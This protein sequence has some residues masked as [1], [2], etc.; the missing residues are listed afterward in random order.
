MKKIARSPGRVIGIHKHVIGPQT[1]KFID[2]LTFYVVLIDEDRRLLMANRAVE[3][4]YDLKSSEEGEDPD[5]IV[6]R[7]AD[8]LYPGCCLDE[9]VKTGKNA[10]RDFFD[11]ITQAWIRSETFAS[12]LITPDGKEVYINLAREITDLK[13]VEAAVEQTSQELASSLARVRDLNTKIIEMMGRIME[14]KDPYTAGH[15]RRVAS[16]AT[17]LAD[18]L[19]LSPDKKEGISLASSIHDIGKIYLPIEILSKP[20]KLN[21]MEFALVM[22]HCEIGH[23]LIASIEFPWPVADMILQHHERLNGSGYPN[24][25]KDDEISGEARII[26]VAD[27]VEA[28]SSYRPYRPSLGLTAALKEISSKKDVLYDAGVVTACVKLFKHGFALTDH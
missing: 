1:K 5:T 24:G 9:V 17:A 2:A 22:T 6:I 11:P 3:R 13:Q 14:L 21:T 4:A 18:E 8:G 10:T 12:D 7:R 27:V 15:Q 23:D 16:L 28:M 19:E 25:I 20:G 26:A